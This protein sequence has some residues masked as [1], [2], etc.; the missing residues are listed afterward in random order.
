MVKYT[1]FVL[2]ERF[3]LVIPE[4]K[5]HF[6]TESFPQLERKIGRHSMNL[7]IHALIAFIGAFYVE[8]I[9]HVYSN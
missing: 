2:T 3:D 5:K 6:W 9:F 8:V 7:T 1:L 4:K